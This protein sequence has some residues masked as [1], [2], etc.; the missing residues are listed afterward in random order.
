MAPKGKCRGRKAQTLPPPPPPPPP[1]PAPGERAT[2]VADLTEEVLHAILRRLTLTDLLRAALACHRWRR[3]ASR[4]LPRAP[5]FLGYFFHP[6]ATTGPPPYLP[7]E[8]GPHRPA[9]FLPLGGPAAP[10]AP[11]LSLNADRGFAIQDVHLGLVLLLPDP[12][13]KKILPRVLVID[14]ASRRPRATRCAGTPGAATG[15][16][17]WHIGNSGRMLALDPV[18]LDF[19]FMLVPAELGDSFRKYRIG[20]LPEDR[21]LCIAVVLEQRLQLWVRGEARWSD[22]GWLVEKEF[23]LRKVLDSVPGMPRDMV[24][25]HLC[26]WLSDIVAGRSGKVFIKTW[27]YGCYSFHL[28]TGK[29]E[30]LETDD[31]L[32]HGDPIFAYFL[33]WPPAFLSSP[34]EAFH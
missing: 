22:N 11:R 29:L 19:S 18:T 7:H 21:R 3:A 17:Y 2:T 32:E 8:Q 10:A 25:R 14:P 9:V 1:H 16:I 20:E 31:G 26:T 27:G 33:A 12:L 6:S 4:A 13:H 15:K 5:P 34:E 23:C 24:N 30:R 28:K